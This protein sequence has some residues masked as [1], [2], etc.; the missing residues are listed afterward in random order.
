MVIWITGLSGAGKTTLCDILS[1]LVKPSHPQVIKID[2]DVVRSL[3][4]HDLGF[5]EDDRKVQ[6][7]RIQRLTKILAD[8][9]A[10][11]LVAA[12]YSHPEL[13]SWIRKNFSEYFEVYIN[14]SLALVERRDSKGIYQ[15][16]AMGREK[17]VVGVDIAW[18]KPQSPDLVF[19]ASDSLT[20]SEMATQII[21]KI[22]KFSM[23]FP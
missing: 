8:Q 20:P 12:L 9:D 22:P 23:I 5:D 14:A 10:V 1:D 21:N 6:I 17:N 7:Q 2:G 16:A 19:E 15:A 3:F 13:L 4:G 18:H 11:V